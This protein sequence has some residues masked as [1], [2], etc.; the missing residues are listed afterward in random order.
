MMARAIFKRS[1]T[2]S[3]ILA[4][5]IFYSYS[6]TRTFPDAIGFGAFSK[7]AYAGS[8]SPRILVVDTLT[9]KSVQTGSNRGSLTWALYQNYPRVIVFEVSG[10][11]HYENKIYINNPYITIAGQTAPSPGISISNYGLTFKAHNLVIQHI[12]FRTGDNHPQGS[13]YDCFDSYNGPNV[14]IDHCSFSWGVDENVS[15]GTS[16][17]VENVTVSNCI[18]SEALAYSLHPKGEHSMGMIINNGRKISVI[19]N[20][21][22]HVVDRAPLVGG[23]AESVV[24]ANNLLYNVGKH[25]IYLNK[26]H[27]ACD[28]SVKSNLMIKG[29]DSGGSKMVRVH[30]DIT[31]GSRIY[32]EDNICPAT[33]SDPWSVVDTREP[34]KFR[35]NSP[36][37]WVDGYEPV[38]A[39][40]LQDY[41]LPKVGARPAD[42]DAVDI[43]IISDV[44]NRT[45]GMINSPRDVG[46]FPVLNKNRVTLDIPANPHADNDN[47]GYTNLEDWLY[48]KH[49]EVCGLG[50]EINHAPNI[51]AQT[52]HVQEQN[53]Q[54]STIGQVQASDPD[55]NPISYVIVSGN[56][57]G[58]FQI[59]N[60]GDLSF[61]DGFVDFAGDPTYSIQV[62]VSDNGNPSLSSQATVT[63]AMKALEVNNPPHIEDQNFRVSESYPRAKQIGQII[64]SDADGHEIS[65]QITSGNQQG[66]FEVS[67][68]GILS[69]KDDPVDFRNNPT[70][71]LGILV[72]ESSPEALTAEAFIQIQL[73]S[74]N[75]T[76]E[77]ENQTFNKFEEDFSSTYIGTIEAQDPNFGQ[78][79]QFEMIPNENSDLFILEPETGSLHLSNDQLDIDGNQTYTLQVSVNDDGIPNQSAQATITVNLYAKDENHAPEI[80]DQAFQVLESSQDN[81]IGRII[82]GDADPGQTIEYSILSGKNSELFSIDPDVGDLYGEFSSGDF[83]Q[84]KEFEI[85]V[86]VQDDG[87]YALSSQATISIQLV[88]TQNAIYIDP[89][90]SND[91]LEDGSFNHPYDS[92]KDVEWKEGFTYLQKNNTIAIEEKLLVTASNITISTYGEG[93][94]AI[95]SSLADDYAFSFYEKSEISIKGLDIQA[96]QAIACLYFAGGSSDNIDIKECNFS[97]AL[98]G[99]RIIDG[100]TFSVKYCNFNNGENAIYSMASNLDV[101]YSIFNKNQTAINLA[102]YSA[103][104]NIYNNVFHDNINGISSSYSEIVVYN[105][106]FYLNSAGHRAINHQMDRIISDYNIFYPEQP[107]FIQI[108]EA[109]YNSLAEFQEEYA[110]DLHSMVSD[111]Q[112]VDMYEENFVVTPESPAVDA[113]KYIGIFEDILGQSVPL[114]SATDI[115]AHEV[116]STPSSI[117]ELHESDKTSYISVYPNPSSGFFQ[118]KST[119]GFESIK[120]VKVINASGTTV[121]S[122]EIDQFD[123]PLG[124]DLTEHSSGIYIIQVESDKKLIAQKLIL[125]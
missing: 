90:N 77:V 66:Y 83:Q 99:L 46:G 47:N 70:F 57:S 96:E 91:V 71:T 56:E 51:Q 41:L 33:G 106:I 17:N 122:K 73:E 10:Y 78:A 63:I 93:E 30:E 74:V 121:Y 116:K 117:E 31:A 15:V 100:Q 64:A 26:N 5:S 115:G 49:L 120:S 37:I 61:V 1:G 6:Q 23:T 102:S 95:I 80:E 52:F 103:S 114:G 69:F 13:E 40:E 58:L 84:E 11:I 45:G 16:T 105:N 125:Q 25:Y 9:D 94:S 38:P 54:V 2:I 14:Y 76:P 92:W 72:A 42:R 27:T 8:S 118:I 119:E 79:L 7:G 22:A 62:K 19:N 68:S 65:Y 113:G 48:A 3:L 110:L 39:S 123:M 4:L 97:G 60:A 21:F 32:L 87:Q 124:I 75:F 109:V 43:R 18:I 112:F 24:I 55:G 108:N 85:I 89:T 50:N 28:Y 111:P 98:Y 59:N 12:R 67:A 81:L 20:L 53:P 104:S 107:G 44:K 36:P 82:A 101:H 88:A 86:Q 35:V 29:K 34:T